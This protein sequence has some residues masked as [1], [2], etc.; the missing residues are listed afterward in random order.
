MNLYE[1]IKKRNDEGETIRMDLRIAGRIV[2]TAKRVGM[3]H[4]VKHRKKERGYSVVCT[5]QP[6]T[7]EYNRNVKNM[8]YAERLLCQYLKYFASH[9]YIESSRRLKEEL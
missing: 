2:F 3:V 7:C 6:E 1:V 5:A 9:L 4:G 8:V